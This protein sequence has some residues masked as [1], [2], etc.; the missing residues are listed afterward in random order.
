MQ[1]DLCGTASRVQ[2]EGSEPFFFTDKVEESYVI[3]HRFAVKEELDKAN[4]TLR[5][6]AVLLL[7]SAHAF[8]F[9]FAQRT[10]IAVRIVLIVVI[11]RI[12]VAG[13]GAR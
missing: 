3:C 5:R 4:V 6:A 1:S 13:I 7:K 2:G 12:D 11:K 9:G 10:T 8:A